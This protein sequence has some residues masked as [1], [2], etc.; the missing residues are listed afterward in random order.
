MNYKN[1]CLIGLR[2]KVV[3]GVGYNYLKRIEMLS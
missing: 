1:C 2:L 3:S